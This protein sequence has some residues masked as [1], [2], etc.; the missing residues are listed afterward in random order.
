M[1]QDYAH[2]TPRSP[3]GSSASVWLAVVQQ[4]SGVLVRANAGVCRDAREPEAE[5]NAT[6]E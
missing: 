1:N 3:R 5:A 6:P 4:A 2:K